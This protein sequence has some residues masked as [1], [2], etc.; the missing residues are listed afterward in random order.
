MK[1]SSRR[2]WA[3]STALVVVALAVFSLSGLALANRVEFGNFNAWSPPERF[4][5]C[6]A[7]FYRADAGPEVGMLGDGAIVTEAQ[8]LGISSSAELE[9]HDGGVGMFHQWS[10][11][12][13]DGFKCA[14]NARVS[15]LDSWIFIQLGPDRYLSLTDAD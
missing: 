7:R 13:P 14:E 12:V 9:P 3:V 6:G 4:D 2:I 15:Q 1:D 11:Y 8:A 5:F 10:V